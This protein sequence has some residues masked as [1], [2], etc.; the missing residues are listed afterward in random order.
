MADRMLAANWASVANMCRCAYW[1]G[2]S[3]SEHQLAA[4]RLLESSD[5]DASFA[6][7]NNA[8]RF[9]DTELCSKALNCKFSGLELWVM[10]M[11]VA[12][13]LSC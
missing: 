1:R 13:R 2:S 3:S 7:S 5:R 4:F 10:Q 12:F 6:Y 8:C 11:S 9:S